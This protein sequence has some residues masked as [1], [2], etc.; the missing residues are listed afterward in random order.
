MLESGRQDEAAYPGEV[1]GGLEA[2]AEG[3]VQEPIETQEDE[4]PG[5][6]QHQRPGGRSNHQ[7]TPEL[8]PEAEDPAGPRAEQ[9]YLLVQPEGSRGAQ[10]RAGA[11]H[12]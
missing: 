9:V 10:Q 12:R 11:V 5:Q 8:Q 7:L 3:Q 2:A 6:R 4:H 1:K